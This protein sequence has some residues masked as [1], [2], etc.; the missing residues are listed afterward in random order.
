MND[1]EKIYEQLK[2]KNFAKEKAFKKSLLVKRKS[3]AR[4]RK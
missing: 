4:K 1:Q 2:G 3:N